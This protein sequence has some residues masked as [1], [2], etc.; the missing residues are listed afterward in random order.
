MNFYQLNYW[1]F[2]FK[3]ILF[4]N[5]VSVRG[6]FLQAKEV[7]VNGTSAVIL[8]PSDTSAEPWHYHALWMLHEIY[9]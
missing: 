7:V 2:P 4:Y 5:Q 8:G 9:L 3:S 6:N 1:M